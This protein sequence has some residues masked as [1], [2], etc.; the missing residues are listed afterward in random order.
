[1]TESLVISRNNWFQTVSCSIYTCVCVR[2]R[3]RRGG[4]DGASRDV[5][6][7]WRHSDVIAG[8]A[9][10]Q[11]V[12]CRGFVSEH[13]VSD[14][15]TWPVVEH[16]SQSS[17]PS[18][19]GLRDRRAGTR[20][21]LCRP[22]RRLRLHSLHARQPE[23]PCPTA[24]PSLSGVTLRHRTQRINTYLPTQRQVHPGSLTSHD[25]M[26]TVEAR[27]RFLKISPSTTT[28]ST[29]RPVSWRFWRRFFIICHHCWTN[30]QQQQQQQ[31]QVRAHEWW[32]R[33]PRLV[34][35]FTFS[36][37]ERLDQP[38][39]SGWYLNLNTSGS[40]PVSSVYWR[41]LA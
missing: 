26:S 7:R 37:S 19:T 16:P 10:G 18:V 32:S 9:G 6:R 21:A 20:S 33:W 14:A 40:C 28:T 3:C 5:G 12:V 1:M 39:S 8:E 22:G 30:D 34:V 25:V 41:M 35:G 15:R 17:Q 24:R 4:D 38:S 23:V 27:G 31:Q 29:G 13:V 36:S 11:G 2:A